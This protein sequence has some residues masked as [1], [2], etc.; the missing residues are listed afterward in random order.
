MKAKFSVNTQLAK[1]QSETSARDP[2]G[3]DSDPLLEQAQSA[4]QFDD[5]HESL[6]YSQQ[7]KRAN[8]NRTGSGGMKRALT[9]DKLSGTAAVDDE[10]DPLKAVALDLSSEANDLD[11]KSINDNNPKKYSNLD[12][13]IVI[14]EMD[15]GNIFDDL[16]IAKSATEGMDRSSEL[17]RPMS[18][19]TDLELERLKEKNDDDKNISIAIEDLQELVDNIKLKHRAEI[20]AI[21]NEQGAYKRI[22]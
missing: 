2:T 14:G 11:E 6:S 5:N 3:N 7:S 10:D 1:Q 9:D 4:K 16:K 12:Q 8:T 17:N 22:I 20:D 18:Q 13:T 15:E 21:M 19:F